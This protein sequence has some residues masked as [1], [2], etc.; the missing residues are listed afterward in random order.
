MSNWPV[1]TEAKMESWEQERMPLPT[2]QM[3]VFGFSCMA[4]VKTNRPHALS[5]FTRT[6][7]ILVDHL[8]ISTFSRADLS[9]P[10]THLFAKW[11]ER[12][13]CHYCP[14]IP[15]G[16]ETRRDLQC[17]RQHPLPNISSSIMEMNMISALIGIYLSMLES[18]IVI[19]FLFLFLF[20]NSIFCS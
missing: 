16:P 19:A 9:A 10:N 20:F 12:S 4:S 2:S 3:P 7:V 8:I 11:W 1:F 6:E 17:H 18:E 15:N 13:E 5:L 14:W